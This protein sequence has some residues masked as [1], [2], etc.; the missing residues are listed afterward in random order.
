MTE[1]ELIKKI[2]ELKTIKP[3][4]DWVLLTKTQI[5]GVEVSP[6][7]KFELFPFFKLA[8]AGLFFLL[9]LAGLIELS[10]GALPGDPL[11]SLKR[12]SEK[13]QAV[14]VSKEERPNLQL[15]LTNKRLEE[16]NK[17]AE[18]NQVENLA[19][20]LSEFETTKIAAKKEVV[21]SIK[22]KSEKEAIKVAKDIAPKLADLNE[23]E[24]KVYATLNIESTEGAEQTAEKAVVEILIKDAKN[25]T[26][27]E[28]QKAD[29]VKVEEYYKSGDYQ[30]ALNLFMVGSLNPSH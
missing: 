24:K 16:L 20:A 30:E 9:L 19:P 8:Y 28:E 26:L 3:R 17:V 14:F 23:K 21:N 13:A 4:K 22:N 2:K 6:K 10:L 29:L 11:Y 27:T 18:T 12:I 5:L 15:E 1:A 25:S 7:P